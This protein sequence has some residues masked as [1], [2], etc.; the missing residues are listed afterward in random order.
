MGTGGCPKAPRGMKGEL[1]PHRSDL[2]T[3][4]VGRRIFG[5]LAE[6]R[7]DARDAFARIEAEALERIFVLHD[8]A[9]ARSFASASRSFATL[10]FF[11]VGQSFS[12]RAR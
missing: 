10:S 3:L 6:T 7:G 9:P 8:R 4:G 1:F 12:A 2:S 5:E 11:V